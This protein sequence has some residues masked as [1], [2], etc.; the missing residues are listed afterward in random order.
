MVTRI[1]GGPVPVLLQLAFFSAA[2]ISAGFLKPRRARIRPVPAA[3]KLAPFLFDLHGTFLHEHN[4][5]TLPLSLAAKK[6][7]RQHIGIIL[8]GSFR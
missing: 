2:F 1:P 4:E 6:E 8:D 7:Y 5:T 3:A